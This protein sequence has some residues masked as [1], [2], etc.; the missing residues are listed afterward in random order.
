MAN[1]RWK[2]LCFLVFA[3]FSQGCGK[4]PLAHLSKT[5]MPSALPVVIKATHAQLVRGEAL[6]Y[7]YIVTFR[8][9]PGGPGL[10]FTDYAA[11]YQSHFSAL[12]DQ[13]LSDPRIKDI[14]F[15]TAIDLNAAVD[16]SEPSGFGSPYLELL[17][18]SRLSNEAL[19]G[20]MTQVDFA[21][22]QD[23]S[24]LLDQW[25]GAGAVWFAEPNYISRLSQDAPPADDPSTTPGG[26]FKKFST[27]YT[28][29]NYWWLQ[30]INL[31]QAY[32]AIANRDLT[33][34]GTPTD[35]QLS[36]NRPIV[37]VLDSGVDYEH[38]A[39]K[40]RIWA[41]TDQNA[42]SCERDTHGCNTT[43]AKRGSL[44]NGDVWPYD[45]AGPGQTCD[46]RDSNCSHGTHV[47]GLIA[48]DHTWT[49]E[50][51]RPAA[52]VCPVCQIMILKIVS[53]VGK[54]SG[55]LDSSIIAAF[56]YVALFRHQ[57]SSAV[58]VI[59]ASFGKFVRSRSVGLLVRLMREKRGTLLVGAAGNEDTLT[60]EFPAAFDDAIA[61][62]AVDSQLRKVSFSNFG[63]WVDIAA[64]G[65]AL[66]STVPGAA[67]DSKSGTSMAT[68]MVAGLAGLMIARYPDITFVELKKTILEG[69]DPSFYSRDFEDGFN[70]YYYYPKIAQ[71]PIRQP[72]LGSGFLNANSSVNKTASQGLPVF[73]DLDRVSPGCAVVWSGDARPR[74]ELALLVALLLAPILLAWR[75]KRRP[76]LFRAGS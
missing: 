15:L 6:P 30:K 25:Q 74:S 1:Y 45:V 33:V 54:D 62:A 61:V 4:G 59:N 32:D 19:V 69:A 12:A 72:L 28:A 26:L 8:G 7:S 18:G 58:R 22:E 38:P 16:D 63:R 56:K 65:N 10:S 48:A 17:A 39:L 42:A 13:Y 43:V 66:L 3:G 50:A 47:A 70:F 36:A 55:I 53:K 21:S 41:N 64:P 68:P 27:D 37:A 9:L 49:D 76:L 5:S 67:L 20:S 2:T 57:G 73:T 23:A 51:G 60:M 71:E 40:S 31:P 34:P 52:G 11:E 44:G 14:R 29:F 75:P 46:N 24:D 35:D